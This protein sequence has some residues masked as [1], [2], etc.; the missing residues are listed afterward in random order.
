MVCAGEG[1]NTDT[2]N[3]HDA[4]FSLATLRGKGS[5]A[6]LADVSAP[7][8]QEME[9]YEADSDANAA[10]PGEQ[11]SDDADDTDEEDRYCS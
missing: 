11:D 3:D 7:T 10:Q 1:I 9:E 2:G 8:E 5:L 4:L 6:E